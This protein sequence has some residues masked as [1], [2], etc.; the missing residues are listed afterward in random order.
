MLKFC[1]DV[2]FTQHE[3][4]K[5]LLFLEFLHHLGAHWGC[6][7]LKTD[8]CPPPALD[9]LPLPL[10]LSHCVSH[11]TDHVTLSALLGKS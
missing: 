6:S 2:C 11:G 9:P 5:G 3:G 8:Q 1:S 7:S 4:P 10:P